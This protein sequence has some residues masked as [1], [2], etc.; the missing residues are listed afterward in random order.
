MND[1]AKD[2]GFERAD[3]IA[4]DDIES[5]FKARNAFAAVEFHQTN[6]ITN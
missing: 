4:L 6:V 3:G 2:L 5:T 1:V